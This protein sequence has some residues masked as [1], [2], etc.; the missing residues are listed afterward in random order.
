MLWELYCFYAHW[1]ANIVSY[2]YVAERLSEQYTQ[3]IE[4][5]STSLEILKTCVDDVATNRCIAETHYHI[6]VSCVNAQRY[7]EAVT[8][9]R[10][11]VTI[12]QSKIAALNDVVSAAAPTAEGQEVDQTVLDARKELKE[13]EEL[14]PDIKLKV[15]IKRQVSKECFLN[16]LAIFFKLGSC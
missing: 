13:L 1:N 2:T 9:F 8:H 15:E 14:I 5:F 16:D 11:A 10:E 7:D 4:D 6:G 3:S 12:L